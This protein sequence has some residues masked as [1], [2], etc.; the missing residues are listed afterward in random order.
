MTLRFVC[1]FISKTWKY[2]SAIEHT[3]VC[4]FGSTRDDG[5][6]QYWECQARFS[7][8]ERPGSWEDILTY[9]FLRSHSFF[10]LFISLLAGSME[11]TILHL[12][13]M[14]RFCSMELLRWRLF[15]QGW[16]TIKFSL[17]KSQ[18]RSIWILC[19]PWQSRTWH[20]IRVQYLTPCCSKA[21]HTLSNE[22]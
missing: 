8:M 11:Y 4:V 7:T 2:L 10:C 15:Y 14:L 9:Y 3:L 13:S 20:I 5:V 21:N 6:I 22:M 1:F 17:S 19:D 18:D 16:V 12:E